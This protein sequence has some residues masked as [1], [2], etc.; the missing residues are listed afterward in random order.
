MTIEKN[1]NRVQFVT[2]KARCFDLNEIMLFLE[3]FVRSM[4]RIA[5]RNEAHGNL[6]FALSPKI[7]RMKFF[8]I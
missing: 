2:I 8:G 4:R 6:V 1:S 3:K 5:G 7:P